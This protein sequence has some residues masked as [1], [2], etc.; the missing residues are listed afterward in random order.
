MSTPPS[1]PA[2]I[3]VVGDTAE[4][5]KLL[6]DTLTTAGYVVRSADSGAPAL[7]AVTARPPDLI[8]VDLRMP[9]LDGFEVCRRL[10]AH[11]GSCDIP[12]L[13]VSS[14][15]EVAERVEALTLGAA[16]FIVTPFQRDELL[17]RVRTHTGTGTACMRGSNGR[18]SNCDV[19]TGNSRSRWSSARRPNS[20]CGRA[21][22]GWRP[23]PMPPKT[24]SC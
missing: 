24:Q 14:S 12:I 21:I 20:L 15:T 2:T 1:P 3:L 4:K 17:A 16:D 18:R 11:A 23:S 13:V 5:W 7:A 6:A 19:P 9:G 8:L 22:P 10:K